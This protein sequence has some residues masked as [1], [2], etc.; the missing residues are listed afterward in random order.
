MFRKL[1][2]TVVAVI[3]SVFS[4]AAAPTNDL[5][6]TPNGYGSIEVGQIRSG[7]YFSPNITTPAP[8]AHVWQ[9][10]AFGDIGFDAV[11]KKNLDLNF[12]AEGFTAFSSP[13][14]GDE[15]QT[16]LPR[17][18][19][20]VKRAYFS[21][22][23]GDPAIVSF[24]LQAGYFPY[25]YS[26]DVRNLGEN[27]F[28]TNAYP[29]LVY[30]QFDYPQVD[31]LGIRLNAQLFDNVLTNDL[32]L[33]S[34]LLGIPAQDWSIGDVIS[35]KPLALFHLPDAVEIGGGV[36]FSRFLSVYQ[37]QYPSLWGDQFF[38]P[39]KIVFYV[40]STNHD[41]TFF[42]WK[43]I[44]VMGRIVIDPK[45]FTPDL[46]IFGENDGR[47]YSEILVDGWKDYDL[48]FTNMK[49]R[50]F[51]SC[52]FNVPT[53][54]PLLKNSLGFSFLDLLNLEFEYCP[55]NSAFSDASLYSKTLG[56]S[57]I[58]PVDSAS[59]GGNYNL[60]RAHWR[61]SVYAKKS[62]LDD[63]VSFIAQVARDHEKV[64]FYYWDLGYMSFPES[65]P[66]INNWWWTFKTEFKF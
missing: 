28:R 42:D 63:H 43:A 37:G 64:N 1:S 20:Y 53:F 9:Q 29:V 18:F 54:S 8:M 31:M 58:Q 41:T 13:Q 66:T 32:L 15:P 51:I 22:G 45:K 35:F 55:N 34:E 11:Y 5:V 10:R 14:R 46:K 33:H 27:L 21:Y 49:D 52:G 44:K 16:V 56:V 38:N 25:K 59:T 6:F 2:A 30:S 65:L 40:D 23:F 62:I 12:A 61:W 4:A 17:S 60:N 3:W 7:F 24:R 36:D 47:I 50:V 48:Y 39:R 57:S 26:S 19:F